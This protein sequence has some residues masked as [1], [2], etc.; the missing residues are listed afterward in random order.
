MASLVF[1]VGDKIAAD[2]FKDAITDWIKANVR[3]KF[4]LDVAIINVI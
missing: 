1:F 3:L 2:N 4:T